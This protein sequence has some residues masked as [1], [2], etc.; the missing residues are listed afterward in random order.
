MAQPSG[1]SG[2]FTASVATLPEVLQVGDFPTP[3]FWYAK[4]GSDQIV[5]KKARPTWASVASEGGSMP[6]KALVSSVIVSL[7]ILLTV[8][9]MSGIDI[10]IDV[11]STAVTVRAI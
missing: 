5:P 3:Q 10:P 9:A 4:C 6:V 8:S 11:G 2:N 1:P 7:L